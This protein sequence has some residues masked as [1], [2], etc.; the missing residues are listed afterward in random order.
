[1]SSFHKKIVDQYQT[2]NSNFKSYPNRTLHDAVS[3]VA[4]SFPKNIALEDSFGRLTYQEFDD[5]TNR[6]ANCLRDKGIGPNDLIAVSIPRSTNVLVTYFALMK[7]GAAFV[8]LDAANPKVRL[9]FMLE[10]S[11]AKFLITTKERSVVFQTKSTKLYLEEILDSIGESSSNPPEVKV[12]VGALVYMIYTSGSTGKP[13]GVP[14]S[15][16][17]LVNILRS[18]V[19]APGIQP[20]DKALALNIFSFDMCGVELFA[21]L[22]AGATVYMADDAT[23]AD[24]KKL[25]EVI[26]NQGISFMQATPTRW[27]LILDNGWN[28][29]LSL[30]AITGGE[31]ITKKLAD[32]LCERCGAVWNMYGPT[33]TTIWSSGKKLSIDDEIITVGNSIANTLIYITNPENG[34]LMP[35]GEIGEIVIAGHGTARGYWNRPELTKE[36]FVKNTFEPEKGAVLYKTGDLGKLLSNGEI[37]CLGR[38]D[39]QIKLRG[40]RIELGEIEAVLDKFPGVKKSIVVLNNTLTTEPQLVAYLEH[41]MPTEETSQFREAVR[42][43]LPTYMVPSFYVRV[44]EFLK[45]PS[46][47]IDRKLLP[48]PKFERPEYLEPLIKPTNKIEKQVLGIWL[49]VLPLPEIGIDDNF[50]E[51]GGTSLMAQ[52]TVLKIRD[53]LQHEVPVTKLFQYPTIRDLSRFISG[54]NT[55]ESKSYFNSQEERIASHDVAIIGMA[56]RF[57]GA[58]NIDEL[59]DIL[60]NGKETIT[61]FSEAELDKSIPEQL[62]KDPMYVAARG[63]VPSAKEFDAAFFG[64]NPTLAK[65]MDPQQRLFLEIAWEVLEETGHLPKHY[66]GTVGV[67]AGVGTNTYYRNNVLPNTDLL[68][69]VGYLQANTVN[70]KDY[71]ATRTAYHLNLNG[72][73]VSVHSAC[74]TSLL[75]VSE[76]TQA[77]RNG[78]CD[79][80]LAGASSVTA[81]INSG[82]L[83]QEGSMLSSDGHCRTFD[84]EGK[85]TMFSDGACVVLL[86]NLESAIADGDYI[87]AVVKGVGVNNDGAR[88]GSFL[89][90][91]AEF[92]ADAIKR[93]LTDANVSPSTISYIEAHGTATPVG[94]PI[95]MEG[96]KMAFGPQSE[97]GYCRIG[98]IKSNMGHLTSAAGAAGLIKAVLAM[99]HKQLPPSLGFKVPNPLIDFE[100][101]PFKVND[102]LTEWQSDEPLRAGISSLG[103][104]GT[105]VH[106]VIESYENQDAV[107]TTGRPFELLPWSA[108]SKASLES[109]GERLSD[110]FER[111]SNI[112][113]SDVSASLLRTREN[114]RHRKF[115]VVSNADDFKNALENNETNKVKSNSIQTV[116]DEMVFL[117]PGQGAQ[118]LEMGKS[119]YDTEAVYKDAIDQCAKLLVEEIDCDIRSIIFADKSDKKAEAKLKD[120]RYTQPA[121]FVTEY[122]LAKLWMSWG[123][124]PTKLCG[125]SIGEFVAAHLSGVFELK[126]ALHL[127]S[128]RGRM[129]SELPG[130]SM[131]SVRVSHEKLNELLPDTLDVAAVNSE[132]L[133]VASGADEDIKAFAQVLEAQEIPN[134]LLFTSHAFHSRMMDPVLAA[135]KKEV[136]HI[137]LK[138]PTIPIISTVTGKKLS[139]EEA[140]SSDY[141]CDHLRA[142]VNFA[143]AAATLLEAE[144]S[145]LLEVGPGN[146]LITLAR[147][148]KKGRT[149]TTLQSLPRPNGKL[150]DHQ[151]LL[152]ALGSLWANGIEP[153]WDSYFKGQTRLKLRLP[154]YAF[155]KKPCWTDPVETQIIQKPI[156]TNSA[157]PLSNGNLT[158]TPKSKPK[159]MRE[160]TILENIADL[161]VDASGIEIEASDKALSFVELGLDSLILTQFALTL[162]R[163]FKQPIT[164]RQLN[165]DLNT[166]KALAKH[167]DTV[168]PADVMAQEQDNIIPPV[169]N[170]LQT[171]IPQMNMPAGDQNTA[172]NLI[173]QQLQLL[174]QQLAVLQGNASTTS[175]GTPQNTS[176]QPA[177]QIIQPKTSE[178]KADE[179]T[180]EERKQHEKP[181]G[182]S[183]KIEKQTKEVGASQR[184]FLD[185]L[186]TRYTKKTKTSKQNT[187]DNR[188]HMSDPRVV[189]GFKPLTKELVYPLVIKKSSGNRMWDLDNNEYLDALNGFG[190]CLFG[191]QPDFIKEALKKQI[192][193]GFEVGPQHPLAGEVSQLLCDFTGHERAALCNTGSEAVLGAMRIARTITARSL[194]VAFTGSYHGINDEGLVRGSKRL[195]TF[196]AAAGI[197]PEAVQNMLV[198]DYGTE[199]SLRIIKERADELAAVLVE[200]VQSRRPEFQPV[201]FLKKVR[202]VTQK[203][204]TALI[205]DEV[206]TGFRCHPAGYQHIS[207]VKADLATY[208]KVIGGGLSVGAILGSKKFMDALDGGYWKFGDDSFPEVG[209]TYFAGTFVRH[210][211]ALAAAKASLLHMKEEG[212]QLQERLNTMT[213]GLAKDLNIAFIERKLPIEVCHFSSLWRMKF[214]EEIPYSELLFVLL[215]EKGIHIMEGF[216]CFLTEAYTE[217]DVK[218][219]YYTIIEGVDEMVAAG[220]FHPDGELIQCTEE[221]VLTEELN[222]PPVPNATLRMDEYGN[223]AWFVAK[224][225]ENGEY[226]KIAL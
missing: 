174:G 50:F 30:T 2:V 162:K 5:L 177:A 70:E 75:A 160:T 158:T 138:E 44:N 213:E 35:E 143:A 219:L 12:D 31:P 216:P 96:L 115:A 33:E 88:K 185:D 49:Q 65:A 86:K 25:L 105:N 62:R 122:A 193:L 209:V 10:D 163:E 34:D 226:V 166:P 119:L 116:P 220:I 148:S 52:K 207:G 109:Y 28:E 13:K 188:A 72:P 57:P 58:E 101:S 4:K 183:P 38:I 3:E 89:A 26:K 175:Y 102:S 9:S 93:A 118:Y 179:L 53:V 110:Y 32:T 74:S 21:P 120:T 178:T 214:K 103:V 18:M 195:K 181:F 215:K 127:I 199:E 173:G 77:I 125:H 56:G 205:F 61:F 85:G 43:A 184:A 7:C 79:V 42:K 83:Y 67:Y 48:E 1:M 159:Q 98:S 8:P 20:E 141:W 149:A 132:R 225:G 223:P 134:T 124:Q 203:S 19:E 87:Y 157:N 29:K 6:L 45:T 172:L 192:D 196:P 197:M 69:K 152:M 198:L 139:S 165:E 218:M 147:Q 189:S 106:V 150:E 211:L 90:P 217:A 64:L 14:I 68:E 27:Q 128:E 41:D 107:P 16:K 82:H 80:A 136:E 95:E 40:H 145:V 144:T 11:E 91:S 156:Q 47:K 54:G 71:I 142:T 36:K 123:V 114:F 201:E 182:A 130:G 73:A 15:H 210:P 224:D 76:A 22:L 169:Y 92:Q 59:W 129:V 51:L 168:L 81:P 146:T 204:G 100:N 112:S 176:V 154:S 121:L 111:N 135:F 212:P 104:G 133:C 131:L 39:Q 17:N 23:V 155:D 221:P 186:I 97:K 206:I 167:L 55:E 153:N 84:A 66:D 191:H 60:K 194:I 170:P 94:D 117:F 171:N 99:K 200:P 180:K 187:Q 46:G 113:V 151:V 208:G 63:V 202:E 164:F 78:Q 24:N 140:T 161:I 108:K 126:D 190:S 37:Q 222:K 137:E